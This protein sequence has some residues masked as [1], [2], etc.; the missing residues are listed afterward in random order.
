[1]VSAEKQNMHAW[2][3]GTFEQ[4]N[5]RHLS[6]KL[7]SPGSYVFIYPAYS[8]CVVTNPVS[9][10]FHL[11]EERRS[12]G[13][14]HK[15]QCTTMLCG[16]ISGTWTVLWTVNSASE[17]AA[18]AVSM[19]NKVYR[20][21]AKINWE[22]MACECHVVAGS[23]ELS[24]HLSW[25]CSL[26]WYSSPLRGSCLQQKRHSAGSSE[27][28][29]STARLRVHSDLLISQRQFGHVA[30]SSL[31]RASARR[32][33]RQLTHIRC[34]FVHCNHAYNILDAILLGP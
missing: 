1:M 10:I 21:Q 26:S 24:T 19:R 3:T 12:T 2:N 32:W 6:Q 15:T 34:P 9:G 31:R 4:R 17:A 25:H 20:V 29:F 33:A 22:V 28:A 16:V 27:M 30:V 18:A 13:I 7:S 5:N 11:P 14:S 23:S 8:T